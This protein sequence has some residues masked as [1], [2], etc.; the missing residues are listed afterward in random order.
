MKKTW[1]SLP[2]SILIS[3][4]SFAWS[5]SIPI[6]NVD[7]KG[8]D[9]KVVVEVIEGAKHMGKEISKGVSDVIS[10]VG[11]ATGITNIIDS[12]RQTLA[13]VGTAHACIA[14]LC[15]SEKIKHDQL[16]QAE[17]EAREKYE[18]DVASAKLHYQ[19]LEQNSRIKLLED[20]M[21]SSATYL[22]TIR[23]ENTILENFKKFLDATS[24]AIAT[25]LKWRNA[26]AERGVTT[27]PALEI[28]DTRNAADRF[29]NTVNQDL[30]LA[31]Q[32][33]NEDIDKL[34]LQVSRSKTELLTDL[35]YMLRN[36]SLD[37]L[38][39]YIKAQLHDVNKEL[40][41]NELK[42]IT[43]QAEFDTAQKQ[44]NLEKQ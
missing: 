27:P 19:Y 33:L 43:A 25:Q 1:I 39:T 7:V 38:S 14:T 31:V 37:A 5:F 41:A 21:Q 11:N 13:N 20:T 8:D 26:L 29:E 40:S 18:S 22:K 34:S 4:Q 10:A 28:Q 42:C 44:Y 3:S 32:Q 30:P 17:K 9:P 6:I 23:D 12:N 16:K 35:I 24:S 15:Y 36:E 2:L